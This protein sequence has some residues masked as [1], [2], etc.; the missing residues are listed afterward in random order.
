MPTTYSKE[1]GKRPLSTGILSVRAA[2]TLLDLLMSF[3]QP[4]LFSDKFNTRALFKQVNK[5]I[6]SIV[7]KLKSLDLPDLLQAVQNKKLPK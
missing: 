7:R 1:S 4:W 6:Y 2:V 3:P 5:Y